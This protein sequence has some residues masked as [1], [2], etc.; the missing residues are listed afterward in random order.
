MNQEGNN[1]QC[2]ETLIR[3]LTI[4]ALMIDLVAGG[5]SKAGVGGLSPS[6]CLAPFKQILVMIENPQCPKGSVFER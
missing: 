4:N 6:P 5:Q 1:Q 3:K 2:G